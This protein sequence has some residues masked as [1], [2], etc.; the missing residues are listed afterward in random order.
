VSFI[1]LAQIIWGLG[2]GL[3]YPTWLG[4]WSINLDRGH[5]SFEWSMYSTLT[6]LGA[7]AAA[8]VGAAIA[9]LFG[10]VATF[11]IIGIMSLA[12]CFILLGLENARM[13]PKGKKSY[14]FL[15]KEKPEG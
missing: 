14:G 9:Q 4:L 11:V 7:A 5:E 6:G 2:S 13:K 12:G 15:P 1:F 10:F 3:A 8:A